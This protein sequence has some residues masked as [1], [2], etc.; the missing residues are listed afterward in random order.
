MSILACAHL[1]GAIDR[2]SEL[3]RAVDDEQPEMVVFAGSLMAPE[4]REERPGD[5]ARALQTA[6]H[7]LAALPCGVAV[8]PGE[9]D[10]PERRVLPVMASQEWV[11][12]HFFCLHGMGASLGELAVTGFGGR[13]TARERETESALRYPGWEARY[14]MAF[15][16]RVDQALLVMVFHTPPARVGELDMVDGRHMG[17]E[18]VTELIGT[19]GPKVAVVAGDRPGKHMYG[20]TVVMSPGRLDR[21]EYALFDP[22]RGRDV[23]FCT[24]A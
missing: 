2:L 4:R 22:R 6:L 14:R 8:V 18:D 20:T 9:H 11:E 5:G 23:R 15:L 19:W 16:T 21:G 12:H 24:S 1:N 3:R 13:I 17:S 10:A 7:E